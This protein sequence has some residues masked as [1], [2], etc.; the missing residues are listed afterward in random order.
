M[1]LVGGSVV[2]MLVFVVVTFLGTRAGG[3]VSGVGSCS[4]TGPMAGGGVSG[5]FASVLVS[6]GPGVVT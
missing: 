5:L 4:P 2:W 6:A 3:G 1:L